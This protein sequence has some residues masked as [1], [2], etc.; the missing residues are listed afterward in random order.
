MSSTFITEVQGST[1]YVT[2]EVDAYLGMQ[3][4]TCPCG[5]SLC[6]ESECECRVL[7]VL[8]TVLTRPCCRE[9]LSEVVENAIILHDIAI[10]PSEALGV[11]IVITTNSLFS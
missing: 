9:E 6:I 10:A 8:S 1:E 5:S 3:Y 4:P 7:K 2:H 11:G